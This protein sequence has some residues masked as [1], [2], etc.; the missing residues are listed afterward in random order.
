MYVVAPQT[1]L[2]AI[3]VGNWVHFLLEIKATKMMF[4]NHNFYS[5][6][7]C[8]N[9]EIAASIYKGK[10]RRQPRLISQIPP[11]HIFKF[12][13]DKLQWLWVLPSDNTKSSATIQNCGNITLCSAEVTVGVKKKTVMSDSFDGLLNIGVKRKILLKTTYC[14]SVIESNWHQNHLTLLQLCWKQLNLTS[15][16]YIW[17]DMVMRKMN[18]IGT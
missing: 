14:S 8:F 1:Q 15:R 5:F 17:P 12:L 18:P 11:E 10:W 16:C 6:N 2:P 7:L 9:C 4:N 13:P 3:P